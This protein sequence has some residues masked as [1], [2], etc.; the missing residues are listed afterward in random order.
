MCVSVGVNERE[1]RGRTREKTFELLYTKTVDRISQYLEGAFT[2]LDKKF[3]NCVCRP[4]QTLGQTL[5]VRESSVTTSLSCSGVCTLRLVHAGGRGCGRACCHE[6]AAQTVGLESRMD[7]LCAL[8]QRVLDV[9]DDLREGGVLLCA[10]KRRGADAVGEEQVVARAQKRC[11][12]NQRRAVLHQANL[13]VAHVDAHVGVQAEGLEA[14]RADR[15]C[16]V[17]LVQEALEDVVRRGD[18]ELP[19]QHSEQGELLLADL[20]FGKGKLHALAEGRHVD[21]AEAAELAC[22]EEG[23][24]TEQLE[25]AKRQVLRHKIPVNKG[26]GADK[27][28]LLAAEELGDLQHP[29]G[30]AGAHVWPDGAVCQ[31]R[32]GQAG[33][34]LRGQQVGKEVLPVSLAQRHGLKTNSRLL[35]VLLLVAPVVVVWCLAPFALC[36]S[37]CCT[38]SQ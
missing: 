5:E 29:V 9:R 7:F 23:G 35:L 14:V 18:V 8:E 28:F 15:L 16:H 38:N 25:A 26:H 6:G 13:K 36:R 27:G 4:N 21:V 12:G 2:T 33:P 32:L 19:V 10:G 20:V 17:H 34:L 31:E 22:D 1:K 24:C 37:C 3:C 30:K 11:G